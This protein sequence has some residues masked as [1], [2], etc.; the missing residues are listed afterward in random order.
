VTSR[1]A[2]VP[3]EHHRRFAGDSS[4]TL[5]KSIRVWARLT[6]TFS[7]YPL[8]VISWIGFGAAVVG[9]LLTA[10]IVIY[11]LWFPESFPSYTAGWASL[12]VALLTIGGIQMAFL[13]ILGEYSGRTYL[14]VNGRPQAA[15]RTIT[16]RSAAA[17]TNSADAE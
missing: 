17:A 10:A 7:V 5:W 4:Y 8:R 9:M 16:S 13:G 2:Q 11:R 15:I 3:V 1:I 6:F 14:K 12:M